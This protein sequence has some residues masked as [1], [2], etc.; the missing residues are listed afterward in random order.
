MNRLHPIDPATAEG[1]SKTLLDAVKASLGGTPNMFRLLAASPTTLEAYLSFNRALSQGA[2]PARIREQI[3]LVSA[4]TNGCDYCASAHT[5]L[6]K[7]AG[8]NQDDIANALDGSAA[9]P[10]A[11]AAIRFAKLLLEKRGHISDADFSQL[12]TVGFSEAE[13]AEIVAHV[14]LNVFTNYFNIAMDTE[15][16]FPVVRT[17]QPKAA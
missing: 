4:E 13:I 10:K 1:K 12:Q 3:A 7:R 6:G 15:I 2:L 5:V 9:D 16:D 17:Q 14:A 11:D 8:L